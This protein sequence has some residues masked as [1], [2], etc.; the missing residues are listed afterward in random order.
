V[1]ANKTITNHLYVCTTETCFMLYIAAVDESSWHDEFLCPMCDEPLEEQADENTP[2]PTCTDPDCSQYLSAAAAGDSDDRCEGTR[3]GKKRQCNLPL[4]PLTLDVAE[5]LKPNFFEDE[6]P[7]GSDKAQSAIR[8][9]TAATAKV[10]K[11][12]HG[13]GTHHRTTS[14][15]HGSAQ[16]EKHSAASKSKDIVR[17][18]M[19]AKLDE[20]IAALDA[21][22]NTV[23]RGEVKR[24]QDAIKAARNK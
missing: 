2:Y 19:A 15:K 3:T 10:E 23:G 5:T 7:S 8:K 20:L 12:V 18:R 4:I 17:T 13:A 9:L 22:D 11:F 6:A 24:A 1:D 21:I 14:G 16:T